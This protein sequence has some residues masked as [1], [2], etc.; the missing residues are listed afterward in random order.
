MH[1]EDIVV[2]TVHVAIVRKRKA[3]E[4]DADARTNICSSFD[5]RYMTAKSSGYESLVTK[6]EKTAHEASLINQKTALRLD[7]LRMCLFK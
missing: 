4:T 1:A 7:V 5:A 2:V 6:E 3:D